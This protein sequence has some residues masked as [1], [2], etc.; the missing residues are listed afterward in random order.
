QP[1][2]NL[3]DFSNSSLNRANS[4]G[5]NVPYLI[6]RPPWGA[7]YA[8]VTGFALWP[9]ALAWCVVEVKSTTS[10][11]WFLEILKRDIG[12]SDGY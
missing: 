12:T 2:F 4:H 3:T 1:G 6:D 11:T 5:L 7:S 9:V 8:M 10:W